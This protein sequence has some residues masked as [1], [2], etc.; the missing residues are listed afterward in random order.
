MP[1]RWHISS[2]MG[3]SSLRSE[4]LNEQTNDLAADPFRP[5]IMKQPSPSMNPA[6]QCPKSGSIICVPFGSSVLPTDVRNPNS[7]SANGR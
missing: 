5:T 1:V 6:S 7:R 2:K 3:S 4:R